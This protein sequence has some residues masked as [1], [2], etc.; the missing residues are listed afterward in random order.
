MCI[1][2]KRTTVRSGLFENMNGHPVLLLLFV[3]ILEKERAPP[4][5]IHVFHSSGRLMP[6][7]ALFVYPR[8]YAGTI[9][10][11]P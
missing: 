9:L 2:S 5:S 7:P 1:R 6:P 10:R 11:N 3:G 8:R 4:R